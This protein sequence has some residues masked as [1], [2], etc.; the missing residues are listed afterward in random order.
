[1]LVL[2]V[3]D[4]AKLAGIIKHALSRQGHAAQLAAT[5]AEA[6]WAARETEHDLVVLDVMIPDPDGFEVC[7]Q[8]RAE[9]R[10]MPVLF[11]TA[12]DAV[13]DRVAG[14]DA[15][16]DDYLV[17]PFSLDELAARVRA[18]L[19]RGPVERPPV[20]RAGDLQLD[21][22]RHAV[23]R[24]DA[25][26][27]VSPREFTLLE[28]LLRRPGEVVS[29]S[30]LLDHVWDPAYPGTSNV[31]DVYVRYLRDKIDRPFG[32]NAIETVRG[33]GYRLREDGG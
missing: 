11:L 28:Y 29:R 2:V 5:G 17:K 3:E 14:L 4:D 19:R 23:R 10:S 30:E 18:L 8:L 6:L 13:A 24:G 20:L 25:M 21:P 27:A 7:R 31:V 9:G 12:R 16:G 33:V 1:V 26:V 15:G 32:R 22:A